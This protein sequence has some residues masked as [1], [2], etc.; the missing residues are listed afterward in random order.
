LYNNTYEYFVVM[1]A[2]IFAYTYERILMKKHLSF[3]PKLLL[4]PLVL[5]MVILSL[6]FLPGATTHTVA[7]AAHVPPTPTP[8]PTPPLGTPWLLENYAQTTCDVQ[9]NPPVELVTYYG[10]WING[11]WTKP[12]TVSITHAPTGAT[13]WPTYTDPLPPA[14]S[15]GIGGVTELAVQIL[16]TTPLGTYTLYLVATDGKLTQQ[17]PI[18]LVVKTQCASY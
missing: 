16:G 11:T 7:L 13:S 1:Y 6:S 17:V 9:G 8:A 10:V 14:S 12:I 3:N 15:N 4:F 18:T 5:S 2:S